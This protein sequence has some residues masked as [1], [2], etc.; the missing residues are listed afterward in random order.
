M[1]TNNMSMA[2]LKLYTV[3]DKK[4]QTY[5]KPFTAKTHGEAERMF[6]TAAKD[7]ETLLGRHPEDFSLWNIGSFNPYTG[8]LETQKPNHITDALAFAANNT[9]NK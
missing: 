5:D 2:K 1:E 8:E 4:T 6:G 9:N 7:T 3:Y